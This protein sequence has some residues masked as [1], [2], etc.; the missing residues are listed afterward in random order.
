MNTKERTQEQISALA[1]DEL[2]GSQ[3]ALALVALRDP[4]TRADW[5]IY[6]QIGDALRSDDMAFSLSE[7][8]AARMAARLDAEPALLAPVAA[9][10]S[11]VAAGGASILVSRL[12]RFAMPGMAAAAVAAAVFVTAPQM[13]VAKKDVVPDGHTA[14]VAVAGN[15]ASRSAAA[16]ADVRVV[17]LENQQG[18]VM[19]DPRIDEYL[20]AHQRF[21]PSVYSS[22][23]YARSAT[24]ASDTGK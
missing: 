11:H 3:I 6:H 13:L 15:S 14:V 5:D 4:A 10:A 22:A 16:G 20:M 9:P 19:R 24:F 21:S 17:T 8:F 7:G 1:D 2:S 12:K 23:Q 18:E